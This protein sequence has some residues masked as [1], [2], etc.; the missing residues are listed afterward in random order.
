MTGLHLDGIDLQC[1]YSVMTLV[2]VI[3][4]V[5]LWLRLVFMILKYLDILDAIGE[6]RIFSGL[7]IMLLMLHSLTLDMVHIVEVYDLDF[8]IRVSTRK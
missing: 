5:S 2:I 8:I 6:C 4:V 7:V 3:V 1:F